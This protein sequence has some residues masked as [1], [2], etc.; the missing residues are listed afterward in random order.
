V[1]VAAAGVAGPDLGV[2]A[3][4]GVLGLFTG[5]LLWFALRAWQRE[6]TRA[7]RLETELREQHQIMIEKVVPA[8]VSAANALNESA[9]LARDLADEQQQEWR[10]RA[11]VTG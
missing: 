2:L 8:L 4:Y 1:F 9:Q 10:R 5:I 11:G 7:E 6:I 3:N